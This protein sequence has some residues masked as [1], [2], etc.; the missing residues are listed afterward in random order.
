MND[1]ERE[2]ETVDVEIYEGEPEFDRSQTLNGGVQ[3]E[4]GKSVTDID[5]GEPL[6]ADDLSAGT[7]LGQDLGPIPPGSKGSSDA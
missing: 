7:P 3:D 4:D 1:L 5:L 2:S 6:G